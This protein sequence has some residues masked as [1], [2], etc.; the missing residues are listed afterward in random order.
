MWLCS[1]IFAIAP[2]AVDLFSFKD[3]PDMYNSPKF[4]KHALGVVET[5]GVAVGK[6]GDLDS[7]VPVL[8][9]L[10]AKHVKYGVVDAHCEC[11][12]R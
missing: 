11:H 7:L 6:L 5:V 2:G 9:G 12:C 10:G 3:E 4:K 1:E 8:K